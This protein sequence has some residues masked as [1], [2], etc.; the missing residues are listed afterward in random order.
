MLLVG[1]LTVAQPSPSS[2][3]EYLDP[4]AE[5]GMYDVSSR[6]LTAPPDNIG[7]EAYHI[8]IVL[9]NSVEAYIEYYRTRQKEIF[10]SWLDNSSAYLPVMKSIFRS[11]DLPVE[12]VYVAMIESG[13]NPRAVSV[14]KA[15]GPWQFMPDTA[16]QYGLRSDQW[17][18]ERRDYI[19][20]TLAAARHFRELHNRLGSW[21]LVLAAYNAGEGK[22]QGAMHRTGSDDF[23]DLK[24]S[25]HLLRE[26]KSFVPR[27]MAVALIARD[28]V[29]YGFR[30]PARRQPS[31]EVVMVRN[32]SADLRA[33]ANATGSSYAA[34]KRLNPELIGKFTPP[35]KPHYLLKIPEG[36]KQIFLARQLAAEGKALLRKVSVYHSLLRQSD[37]EE[38][39]VHRSVPYSIN[40]K[41]FTL[42][43]RSDKP[44]VLGTIESTPITASG[45][46]G[47]LEQE[48]SFTHSLS[49]TQPVDIEQGLQ[50]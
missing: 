36:K 18:D 38:A 12:L 45:L 27:F 19:K 13:L 1:I 22:V 6:T 23:W 28:P 40:V 3:A 43:E 5:A 37:T 30:E 26:T 16:R 8:P 29:S 10:Q 11:E 44:I 20:S 48:R 32:G 33:I 49:R 46:E 35:D 34:I 17:V 25:A 7:E 47:K 42:G 9:N 14:A 41:K 21:L 31:F 2:A 24:E 39:L 50:L 4:M 15:V